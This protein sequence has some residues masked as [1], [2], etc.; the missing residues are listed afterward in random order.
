MDEQL[1]HIHKK[2]KKHIEL[3]LCTHIQEFAFTFCKIFIQ[4][5]YTFIVLQTLIKVLYIFNQSK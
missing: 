3:K 5:L 4:R 2:K 1:R